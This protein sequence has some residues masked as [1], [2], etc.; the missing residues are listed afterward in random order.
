MELIFEALIILFS[1][2]DIIDYIRIYCVH[3]N[4]FEERII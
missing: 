3:S 4:Y 2:Q 1:F